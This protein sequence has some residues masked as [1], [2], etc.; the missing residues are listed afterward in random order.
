LLKNY[1]IEDDLKAYIPE[2]DELLYTEGSNWNK[3]KQAAEMK[4]MTDFMNS[5][6]L[7]PIY[8]RNDLTLRNSLTVLSANYSDAVTIEDIYSRTRLIIVTTVL[9]GGNKVVTLQG[10]DAATD[11]WTTIETVTI[12][13]IGT[14]SLVITDMYKFYR[15]TATVTA[16]TFAY[17]SSLT[18]I[19]YDLLYLY[20]WAM[21]VYWQCAKRGED[22]YWLKYTE[23]KK[24]YDSL[25]LSIVVDNSSGG[26]ID[27][28]NGSK[29]LRLQRG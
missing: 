8:L 10:R 21:Q 15:I 9:T 6:H 7:R 16:G 13:A 23:M 12:T 1:L 5:S 2:L 3:E 25:W 14:R 19:P 27:E 11:V 29:Y 18:R 4:V 28:S 20:Q 24:E 17:K 22:Q 26:S